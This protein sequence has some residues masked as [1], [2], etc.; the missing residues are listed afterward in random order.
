MNKVKTILSY[1]EAHDI[2]VDEC[3]VLPS[4]I[5]YMD[6]LVGITPTWSPIAKQSKVALKLEGSLAE[7]MSLASMAAIH[8][9]TIE[10]NQRILDTCASPGMK[11]LYLSKLHT[12]LSLTVNDLSH[13]R[14]QRLHRLF[15][16]HNIKATIVESDASTADSE[17]Y[18]DT[19]D[20]ILIDAPCSG[21][22]VILSGDKNLLGTW[23]PAKVKRL[24]QLQ[25]KI[26]KNAIKSLK[27]D[28]RLVY[29]TCTLNKNE[30]E[31]VIKKALK[32]ELDV[33]TCPLSLAELPNLV[34]GQAWRI[35][36]SKN[37]IGFFI[38]VIDKSK[39]ND[40]DAFYE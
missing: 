3:Q 30:N 1:L 15:V 36:P 2:L 17:I 31:R 35:T 29:A 21:E 5:D 27:P 13:G 33:K 6:E 4:F 28:G 10:D 7:S 14:L 32:I 12:S 16:K 9:L 24:Q 37:S 23:S 11:S 38:A 39:M 40:Y 18:Q 8:F 26:V 22:G 20:R 34:H 19:Y 25:I